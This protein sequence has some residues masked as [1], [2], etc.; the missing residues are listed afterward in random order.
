MSDGDL[1]MNNQPTRHRRAS[2]SCLWCAMGRIGIQ[3]VAALLFVVASVQAQTVYYHNDLAGTPLAATNSSGA[4][5]WKESYR[6]Y[7]ERLLKPDA[8]AA[9]SQWFHGKV[10]DAESGLEYFGARYYD[11]VVGRFMG[12]DPQRFVDDNLHSFNRFAY[13]NNNPYRYVDRNGMWAED[14][15]LAIP[16]L[17]LGAKSFRDNLTNGRYSDAF[18]DAVGVVA[19]A[20]ATAMP[21]VPGGAGLAIA[22]TRSVGKSAGGVAAKGV[23]RLPG[24]AT[25]KAG[26]QIG[27][28]IVDSKGNAMIE[29]VGGKTVAAGK[30][31]VD[32]HTLY[33]NGS[34]YQRL[35]PQGHANNPTPH[36]HGHAPG[37]GPGMKG[38]GPSLDVNGN[39]VP[40]NSPA[41]HWPIN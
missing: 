38:Q 5:L 10:Q 12:V 24:P 33:P 30:G 41:A 23:G 37:T 20:W 14:A 29:P 32:T 27:R 35:N 34:N 26:N 7:G 13:G 16:G 39:V 22:A 28:I 1:R 15:A 3:I 31:G 36:G 40:W 4:L 2:I 11:P 6:P 21:G 17:V 8:S 18:V 9:N 19:D 25:D